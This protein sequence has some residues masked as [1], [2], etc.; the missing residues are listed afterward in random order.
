MWRE[1]LSIHFLLQQTLRA[2][3]SHFFVSILLLWPICSRNLFITHEKIHIHNIHIDYKCIYVYIHTY[4]QFISFILSKHTGEWAAKYYNIYYWNFFFFFSI[5]ITK[6]L[7]QTKLKTN[8]HT[9]FHVHLYRLKFTNLKI[10]NCSC[11]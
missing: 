3:T 11:R 10:F 8:E 7:Q 9:I 4:P 6:N 1:F 2:S 5:I